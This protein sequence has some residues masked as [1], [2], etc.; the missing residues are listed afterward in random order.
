[1]A[2]FH[3]EMNDHS[4]LDPISNRA[5]F[6]PTGLKAIPSRFE[7]NQTRPKGINLI[8]ARKPLI[9][10]GLEL[11]VCI[12]RRPCTAWPVLSGPPLSTGQA[13]RY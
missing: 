9:R 3:S 11:P 2:R 7:A 5:T 8:P 10:T 6:V 1:M 4:G 13:A 12:G